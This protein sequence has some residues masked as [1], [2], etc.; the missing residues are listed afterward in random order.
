MRL[1]QIASMLLAICVGGCGVSIRAAHDAVAADRTIG[2]PLRFQ[3]EALARDGRMV[4]GFV[5]SQ[6]VGP[7]S[8][9]APYVYD[10]AIRK[11]LVYRDTLNGLSMRRL[12]LNQ[13]ADDA[14]RRQVTDDCRLVDTWMDQCPA[15]MV[16]M[17]NVKHRFCSIFK[18]GSGNWADIAEE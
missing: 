18:S 1:S 3:H 7:P 10:P 9:P 2:Q 15:G 6:S 4:C 17:V 11:A 16:Y 12:M 13:S 8:A 5:V 14:L